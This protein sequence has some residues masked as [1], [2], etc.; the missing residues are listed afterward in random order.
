MAIAKMKVVWNGRKVSNEIS[1]E[2]RKAEKSIADKIADDAR[3]LCPVGVREGKRGKGQKTW[4]IRQPGTLKNSIRVE[5]GKYG[6]YLVKVGGQGEWGD[7][8]YATF[9]ELGAPNVPIM[10]GTKAM[11]INNRPF[12][13]AAA[14]KNKTKFKREIER[15][16]R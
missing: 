4:N 5:K 11:P 8:F 7:A 1:G 15:V 13:K 16:L 10:V 2:L 14:W 12:M 9:I 6:G 3:R